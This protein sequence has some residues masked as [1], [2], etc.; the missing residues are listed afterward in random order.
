M[1]GHGGK[2][3]LQ[4]ILEDFQRWQPRGVA[5]AKFRVEHE[6]DRLRVAV[7]LVTLLP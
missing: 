1:L 2:H 3:R 4:G 5:V 7:N 6:A